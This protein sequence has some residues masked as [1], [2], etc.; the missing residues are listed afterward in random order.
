MVSGT[1]QSSQVRKRE[2]IALNQSLIY[3]HPNYF[4]LPLSY[5][6]AKKPIVTYK[7]YW[8]GGFATP[9]L[10]PKLRVPSVLRST[11][12][13]IWFGIVS[14]SSTDQHS[15]WITQHVKQVQYVKLQKDH[16]FL[17][18]LPAYLFKFVYSYI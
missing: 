2:K 15:V 6:V 16:I 11:L 10:R 18:P 12:T 14:G 13:P 5:S 1:L 3:T 17:S 9:N 8:G 7:K 4:Y